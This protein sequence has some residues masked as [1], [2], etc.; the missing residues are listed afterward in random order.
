MA[1]K[2]LETDWQVARRGISLLLNDK[3]E[4]ADH[5]FAE[6][7]HSFHIKAGRCF[8]LFMNA[9]MTFEDEKLLEA[10]QLLK[11]MEKECAGNIG[12]LKLMKSKVLGKEQTG[13]DFITKLEQ[14]IVLADT[15]VCAAILALLQQEFSGFVKGGWML[16]K[17]WRVYQ[18]T[19]SQILKLYKHTFGDGPLSEL[20]SNRST[21]CNG[22]SLNHT[23]LSSSSEWSISSYNGSSSSTAASSPSG[24]RSSLS[25]FLS[26]TGITSEQQTPFVKST[27]VTRLMAAVS[28]GYG[29]F[30][31]CVSLLPP[32]FLKLTHVLGFK[33]DSSA[34]LAALMYARLSKDMRA[35]LATFS[36]LSYYT[37]VR[38]FFSL[39]GSKIITD[40][41]AAEQLLDESNLNA[42]LLMY[43]S[44]VE[45]SSQREIKMLCLH[46]VAW[47]HLISLN[48][49]EAQ[50][51]LIQLQKQSRW[52]KS[53]YAYLAAV[54]SGSD[55]N[56]NELLSIYRELTNLI[57]RT[58]M[59]TQLG[60]FVCRRVPKLVDRNTGQ[61]HLISY[62][63][64]LVYELLY[65]WNAIPSCTTEALENILT[66]WSQEPLEEPML[67][68]KDLI[69]GVIYSH[70]G[71][72]SGCMKC[73]RNCLR[74]RNSIRDN[75]DEHITVHAMYELAV[76]LCKSYNVEEGRGLLQRAQSQF[77]DYDF[78]SR[79]NVRIHAALRKYN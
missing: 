15:Q 23:P 52:S 50:E 70:L 74:R 59:D 26:L 5:L 36:L 44:A 17:A 71:E 22:S 37:F 2:P 76:L 72:Q 73:F 9:I 7:P 79:I 75:C 32:S 3:I 58:S 68:L 11:E 4:E 54:C 48:Y 56:F 19:Y 53:F 30:Q 1:S 18:H 67:G 60:L 28:F 57:A 77:K 27:E 8:A 35:P 51:S 62:Y 42:A 69:E 10:T 61:P 33:G 46:E 34:A 25:M 20:E 31:L 38:P 41:K 55:G 49:K 39:E 47:C 16:R 65:L 29:I 40:V 63:K 12:W 64:L 14:Q 45:V 43:G 78:E 66:E 6:R 13:D 21:P 24:L